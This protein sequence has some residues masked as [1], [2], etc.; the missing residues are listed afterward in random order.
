MAVPNAADAEAPEGFVEKFTVLKTAPRELWL[1][2]FG[3]VMETAAYG[4]FN[5]GLMLHLI[6]D[7]HYSDEGAGSFVGAWATVIS[8]FIFLVGSLSDAI[9]IRKTLL[10]SFGLCLVTRALTAFVSDPLWSPILALMPMTF[11]V[12]MTI[13]VMVAATRRLTNLRQRSMAFALLYVLMNVGFIIAG[14][15][16]D[17][18]RKWMGKD[19]TLRVPLVGAELSVYETIFL[20]A[21]GFT[22]L[23][24]LPVLSFFRKGVE[25]SEDSDEVIVDPTAEQASGDAPLTALWGVV[26]K[27]GKIFAEV[28]KERAFYRFLL[29]LTVVVGVRMV[30]YHM[31]YTLPPWAD[32]E[33]G[34]G[35]RFGTAWG[36]INPALIVILAPLVGALAS[37]ISS[38]K[39][40]IVGTTLSAVPV[41]LLVLPPDFFAFLEGTAL[42]G[43]TKWLLDIDGDLAP[44]YFTL[45]IF[46]AIFSVGEAIW[47]PRLYEYTASVAPKGREATYMGLSLLPMFVAKLTVGPLSGVLLGRYCPAEGARQSSKLWLVVAVMAIATPVLIVLLKPII[48]PKSRADEEQEA[49]AEPEADDKTSDEPAPTGD[50]ATEEAPA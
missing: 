41:F 33:L 44:L 21:A 47:S 24:L 43:A 19:S 50:D 6:N 13:P 32:R 34:Y 16:F 12:A 39:M 5:M 17:V 3:K 11:G 46:A 1:V 45:I 8:L 2:Y 28:F 30:F 35:S 38:Y 18:V 7:L 42:E 14:K 40:M 27:T 37:K 25:M 23:G 31:H 4:L 36:V 49:P 22:L 48:R 20:I 26:F 29:L 9:G 15:L 10:L